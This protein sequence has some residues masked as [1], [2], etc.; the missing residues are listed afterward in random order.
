MKNSILH[1]LN[2]RDITQAELAKALG[3]TKQAVHLWVYQKRQPQIKT[4]KKIANFFEVKPNE[5]FFV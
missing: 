3:V 1:F 5:I 4:M 2:K